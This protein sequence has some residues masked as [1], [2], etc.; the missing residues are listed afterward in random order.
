MTA[1]SYGIITPHGL[2]ATSLTTLAANDHLTHPPASTPTTATLHVVRLH[3]AAPERSSD[4]SGNGP[5]LSLTNFLEQ[6]H[7]PMETAPYTSSLPLLLL[8]DHATLDISVPT[9]HQ[10]A[11]CLAAHGRSLSPPLL[12]HLLHSAPSIV[13][14]QPWQP[15]QCQRT[16]ARGYCGYIVMLQCLVLHRSHMCSIC[17]LRM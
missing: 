12:L 4:C 6:C 11:A 16:Q 14:S 7:D 5:L 9:L 13:L 10:I 8:A 1:D 3:H 17:L 15:A 2:P